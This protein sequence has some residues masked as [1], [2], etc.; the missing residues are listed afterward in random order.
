MIQYCFV[1]NWKKIEAVALLGYLQLLD[2][3]K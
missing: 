3:T 1:I 2:K